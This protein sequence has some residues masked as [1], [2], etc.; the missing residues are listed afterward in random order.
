[1]EDYGSPMS[2]IVMPINPLY[3]KGGLRLL[4]EIDL[5]LLSEL[6]LKKLSDLKDCPRDNFEKIAGDLLLEIGT[7]L[8]DRL[9]KS[10]YYELVFAEDFKNSGLTSHQQ[11]CRMW[12]DVT[13]K[14]AILEVWEKVP[15]KEM[16]TRRLFKLFKNELLAPTNKKMVYLWAILVYVRTIA[17]QK[18]IQYAPIFPDL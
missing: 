7:N 1:M 10:P 9:L 17:A 2:I 3:F 11:A 15:V 12:A 6:P 13:F 4:G 14:Q 16:F 8:A 5:F 18:N